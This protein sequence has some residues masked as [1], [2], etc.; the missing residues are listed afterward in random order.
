MSSKRN[1][2]KK[3]VEFK[4]KEKHEEVKEKE[5]PIK[6]QGAIRKGGRQRR[7][8]TNCEHKN[9]LHYAKGMC[10]HCYHL[11]GRTKAGL[12]TNCPHNDRVNYCKGM[13]M[14]CYI[15]GYNK[16]RKEAKKK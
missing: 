16:D 2:K 12:A 5:K 4:E 15:N 1:T 9:A 10:N 6:K 3:Q 14:N 13:C 11:F 7:K 8:I